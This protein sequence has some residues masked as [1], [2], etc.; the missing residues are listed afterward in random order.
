MSAERGCERESGHCEPSEAR[1]RAGETVQHEP[2]Q[3]PDSASEAASLARTLSRTVRAL[4]GPTRTCSSVAEFVCNA[5][6]TA[7]ESSVSVAGEE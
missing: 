5:S 2:D 6:W 3:A 7:V 1:S 4:S